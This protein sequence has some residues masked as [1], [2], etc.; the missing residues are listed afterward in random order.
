MPVCSATRPD[1]PS[2][3]FRWYSLPMS[4]KSR[5]FGG[6]L[7]LG[8]TNMLFSLGPMVTCERCLITRSSMTLPPCTRPMRSTFGPVTCGIARITAVI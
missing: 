6:T 7:W 5:K 4:S 3:K 8:T 1:M 2:R